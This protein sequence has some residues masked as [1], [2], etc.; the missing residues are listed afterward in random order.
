MKRVPKYKYA[1]EFYT[2]SDEKVRVTDNIYVMSSV[3]P[4]ALSLQITGIMIISSALWVLGKASNIKKS[5]LTEYSHFN[6][7]LSAFNVYLFFG[8]IISLTLPYLLSNASLYISRYSLLQLVS[9]VTPTL[10]ILALH[11]RT[12]I[13]FRLIVLM[14][15]ILT[16]LFIIGVN[17]GFTGFGYIMF[18]HFGATMNNLL[19]PPF[20]LFLIVIGITNIVAVLRPR[21]TDQNNKL[22][23][24]A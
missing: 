20:P 8:V 24:G 21:N 1:N 10:T 17:I 13:T 12:E 9:F 22:A 23:T 5:V 6:K 14:L 7:V 15:N 2:F 16:I 11:P 18:I 4:V 3:N 19:T